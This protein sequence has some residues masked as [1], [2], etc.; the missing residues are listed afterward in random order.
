MRC[1][2]CNCEILEDTIRCPMCDAKQRRK[3]GQ[4]LKSESENVEYASRDDKG[5]V[6]KGAAVAIGLFAVIIVFFLFNTRRYY[7][8]DID[9]IELL[10]NDLFILNQSRGVFTTSVTAD[11]IYFV[12]YNIFM[13]I[14]RTTDY[15]ETSELIYDVGRDIRTIQATADAIY[16]TVG[17]QIDWSEVDFEDDKE[18]ISEKQRRGYLYRYDFSTGQSIRVA[19]EI[20]EKVIVDHLVFHRRTSDLLCETWRWLYVL[21]LIT[22]DRWRFME[23]L[24]ILNFVIDPANDQIIFTAFSEGWLPYQAN[25]LGENKTRLLEEESD[26]LFGDNFIIW[27]FAFTMYSM[28]LDTMEIVILDDEIDFPVWDAI[29]LGEYFVVRCFDRNLW[30]IDMNDT[31]RRNRLARNIGSFRVLGN[32]IIYTGR[33]HDYITDLNGNSR[34]FRS[35]SD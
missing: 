2:K 18:E 9:S 11:A 3:R 14:R 33:N 24:E 17:A 5:K 15:F 27:T 29:L 4:R 25:L 22:K 28:N 19:D 1:R 32:Y 6:L 8:F 12:D 23:D 30:L 34:I 7:R 35:F 26:V 10:A 16:Y 31:D 20:Y 21:D 13:S